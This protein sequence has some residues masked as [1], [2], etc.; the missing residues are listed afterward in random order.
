MKKKLILLTVILAI[1]MMSVS[2]FKKKDKKADKKQTQQQVEN[3]DINTD[4]F[5]LGA[6][7]TNGGNP[8][9]KN[10]TP[11]E[12]QKLIDNQIDPVKVSEAITKAEAGDKE[13]IMSLSQLYFNLKD[14]EKVKKF[15]QMGVDRNYPEA[16][17]NLAVI[18][19]QEGNTAEANKLMARLPKNVTTVARGGRQ[20]V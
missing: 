4:I 16:I 1:G 10:L 19:K 3:K 5:N 6:Q 12:Q 9:I 14:N 13:A 18:L 8:D 20:Q 15:L 2:C 11:E 17:Y 7:Q